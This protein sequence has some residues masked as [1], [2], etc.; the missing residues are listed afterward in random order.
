LCGSNRQRPTRPAWA[1]FRARKQHPVSA[2]LSAEAEAPGSA[3]S[4][5]LS[6][7]RRSLLGSSYSRS[8]VQLPLPSAYQNASVLDR[9]GVYLFRLCQMRPGRTP[10]LPRDRW[11][12]R[13]RRTP[14]PAATL[15]L[16]TPGP[17][18]DCQPLT[19]STFTRPHRGFTYVRPSGLLL[20][21]WLVMA[22]LLLG[23]HVR[24]LSTS[25][26]PVPHPP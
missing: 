6:P 5:G 10:P 9:Y 26:L 23:L 17:S 13:S 1:P 12:S 4:P 22:H 3:V 2:G 15:S 20:A 8:G 25:P 21:L 19:R 16:S 7:Q 24:R 14:P 11:W 18:A